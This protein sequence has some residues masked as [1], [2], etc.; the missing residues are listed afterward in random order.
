MELCGG[1]IVKLA[2]IGSRSLHI[3]DLKP[4]IP[5]QV[6][7]IVS[8]GAKGIDR[9]ARAYAQENNV[10]LT[11]FL[12]DYA[13]YRRAAPLRRN[14]EIVAYADEVLAFWDGHSSG[15]QHVI[16]QCRMLGKPITVILSEVE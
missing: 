5:P 8:G 6:T 15:T 1:D 3:A 16:R 10:T 2:I 4:Y 12:P 14:E 11:E 9:C 13:R 7:E